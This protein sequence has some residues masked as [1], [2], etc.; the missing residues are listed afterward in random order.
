LVASDPDSDPD[1][2]SASPP[3]N[4]G[5][6]VGKS[7]FNRQSGRERNGS[8]LIGTNGF[9]LLLEVSP[10]KGSLLERGTRHL[11]HHLNAQVRSKKEDD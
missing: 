2:G 7:E 4:P 9:F 10:D 6:F 5:S 8:T 1:D 11:R 3:P